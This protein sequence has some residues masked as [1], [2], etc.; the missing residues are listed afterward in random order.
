M[1]HQIDSQRHLSQEFAQVYISLLKSFNRHNLLERV[2][3]YNRQK[4]RFLVSAVSQS[5][6]TVPVFSYII[7]GCKR[8]GHLSRFSLDLGRWPFTALSHY[9][10]LFG[11]LETSSYL[12][13]CKCKFCLGQIFLLRSYTK[14]KSVNTLNN[15]KTIL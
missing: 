1:R 15:S 9:S 12:L 11:Q 6:D 4:N 10:L 8:F 5:P 3:Q 13:L 7:S 14:I 2:D